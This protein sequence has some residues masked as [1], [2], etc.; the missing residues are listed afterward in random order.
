M[1]F[2]ND[3]EIFTKIV[4]LN[5]KFVE[6]WKQTTTS[7]DFITQCM[8]QSIPTSFSKHSAERGGNV[9]GLDKVDQNVIM[10]LFNI[11]VKTAEEEAA[12]SPILFSY[13]KKMQEFAAEKKGLID[14][15]YLNY[16][17]PSQ[18][19]LGSYGAENVEKLR[20]VAKKYDP[21]GIFQTRF[22]GGFK[23]SKVSASAYDS[24][25]AGAIYGAEAALKNVA[26]LSDS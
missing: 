15:Q 23:I 18:D 9:L 7:P 21:E 25:G 8:F 2:A 4:E 11:A 3:A 24:V 12:A 20:A 17:A 16:A 22:P 13:G 1:T 6:E 14:W 19:P 5:E 10:L 26:N